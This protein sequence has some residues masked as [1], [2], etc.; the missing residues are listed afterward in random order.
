ML[1][2]VSTIRWAYDVIEQNP[3]DPTQTVNQDGAPT[4]DN[5]TPTESNPS[6]DP[7]CG[8][9]P[10]PPPIQPPPAC[11]VEVGYVPWVGN[12]RGS[13][14]IPGKRLSLVSFFLISLGVSTEFDVY[15]APGV[16]KS[17]P[18]RP[19]LDRPRFRLFRTQILTA[20]RRGPDFAAMLCIGHLGLWNL[21][22]V[23]GGDQ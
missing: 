7:S 5:C 1:R 4:D 20:A 10:P 6:P 16:L 23:D 2:T 13:G 17:K 21:L 19:I 3:P 22:P 12:F 11:E 15:P 18:V 14:L 8:T 9:G